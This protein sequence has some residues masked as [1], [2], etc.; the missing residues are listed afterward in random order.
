MPPAATDP[1]DWSDWEIY[2]NQVEH[3]ATTIKAADLERA[4]GNI[5]RHDWAQRY[6]DGLQESADAI[7]TQVSGDYLQRMIEA[8][9]PGCVG[10]CPACRA[11][12]LP[13]HPNGQW[14]W[15]WQEPDKLTCLVCAT[16]FPHAEY[17][18]DIAVHCTWGRGQVFTFVGGETFRCFGY[19]EA[20]PSLSGITRARKV[21]HVTGQ[22]QRLATAHALT[23]DP[24]YAR[25]AK[26]ILLR[27]ADV[28]P[29]YLVRAGYGYG[30]Y[31][32]MDPHVAAEH[33]LDLPQ[34]ELVYPPNKPD[35]R[36]FTGYW[37]ASRIGTSGMDG[38]WVVRVADAY[39]LTCTAQ[40]QGAPVYTRD[41]RLRI[42]RDVLL[43]STYLAAC[44]TAI[45]N[46]SV[47]NRAG[48]AAVGMCVGHPGLVHFG[49]DGFVKTVD[50]WF[51]PDGGSSESPAYAMM[52]MGGIRPFALAFRGTCDPPGYTTP[53][54]HRLDD[55]DACRDTLY[56]D[57][58]QALIWTLQ[59]DLRF[60]PSA[61]SYLST[62]IDVAFADVI[63]MAYPTDAHVALL[64]ELTTGDAGG[65]QQSAVFY[66][67]MDIACRQVPPLTL[68]D[69]VFPYLSQGYL[70]SGN[71]GRAS[72][73]LLNAADHGAHH[74]L[75]GLN[76]YYWKDGREL[77]SDLGYLWDHP[78][79]YQTSRT[80]A[81]NLAMI[82]GQDQTG[83]GRRG[84]FHLFSV[85]PQVKAMEASCDGYGREAVYRRTVLQMD[86]GPAGTY[87]LDLFR[88]AGGRS[89]DYLFHG[90]HNDY[91]LNGL[92]LAPAPVMDLGEHS[93]KLAKAQRGRS[94]RSWRVVWTFDDAYTFTALAPG[95]A[96]ELVFIGNG[97]GQRDHRNS[98][99][100]ATLPYV[101]R[102]REGTQRNDL[103]A[104]VYVGQQSGQA[105]VQEI[106][107]LPLPAD[108]PA[109]AVAVSVRTAHGTDVV[110]SALTPA[111]FTVVT[112]LGEVSTD[113][114]LAAIVTEAGQPSAACLTGGAQ[115]SAPGVEL[116]APAA[117]LE[118][119]ILATGASHGSAWFDVDAEPG[120]LQAL[121]G[122]TLFAIGT[123]GARHGYAIRAVEPTQ[124]GCRVFTKRDQKGFEARQAE[125]WD[126][127]VTVYGLSWG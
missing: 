73:L 105:L 35:R 75:D 56:G 33:I 49:L 4:L 46:K 86:H 99:V 117:T 11:R 18:E 123:D 28:F 119:R 24:R 55:F 41:E 93:P 3:P 29:E 32:G 120:V 5:R 77:L 62:T 12:G 64:Q 31:A 63:A 103:F 54:G 60:P 17:P 21:G 10:P 67:D 6:V 38:G 111:P 74:H 98:D 30:E 36:I 87:V 91:R 113:G 44:D 7:I 107:V 90:P 40:E 85:T 114:R 22:L 69:V 127:P 97:W 66:R 23:R 53:H 9:T 124:A 2:R 102:H 59:G 116:T 122:Q 68:P 76:L 118:G 81:H 37:S 42:E 80:G 52:T 26:A 51:L 57:C 96:D 71:D 84:S 95:N 82:N 61:D 101:L 79:K 65:A 8:T 14:S 48:A 50:G 25:A 15:S 16:V 89:A 112:N 1:K 39:S 88:A 106:D 27:F 58:W 43:E 13:W 110:I 115:L 108:A 83:R 78:D 47:G 70:R 19:L 126:L 100:G 92:E 104:T 125:R 34:D 94:A 109:D 121:E 72:Q 45:N 20:R